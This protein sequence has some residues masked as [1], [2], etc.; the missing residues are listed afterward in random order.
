M[1]ASSDITHGV[2]AT[3]RTTFVVVGG[4]D[5]GLDRRR[6]PSAPIPSPTDAVDF[7]AID[8]ETANRRRE[9]AC[10]VG[11]A[12]V[13][14][15][16]VVEQTSTLINPDGEF[17]RYNVAIIGIRPED[18]VDAPYF[19]EVWE[20]LAPVLSGRTIVA[21]VASFDLGVLR[22]AVAR[23][24]LPGI[25]MRAMC[26]WRLARRT[27]PTLPAY[28]L[29]YLAREL[30]LDLDH[31]EA[32]SDAAASA[33]VVLAAMREA[34]AS[35]LDGML[36]TF[37]MRMGT[38]TPDSFVGVSAYGGDLRNVSGVEDADPDHP[39]YGRRICFTGAMFSMTRNEAAE[40]IVEFGADFKKNV[41]A[42]TD[43]LVIGDADFVQFADGMQTGKMQKAAALREEGFEIEIMAERDFLALL[44]S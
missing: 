42:Q 27:W 15:G 17:G 20:V 23:Y 26:S 1:S 16:V 9:S 43:M 28:G 12:F 38:L 18:V 19:P 11:L 10:A 36:D 29:S 5:I 33:G 14:N 13:S 4:M 31:H 32:G 35:S 24:E 2:R 34:G 25:S 37:G 44:G 22:Q 39:L 30:G 40:R 3:R 41:S 8:F 21:H 7:V 6:V